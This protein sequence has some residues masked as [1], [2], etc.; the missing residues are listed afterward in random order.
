MT[1][2]NFISFNKIIIVATIGT[3]VEWAEFSCYGYLAP[4][5]AQL[6]FALEQ[7]NAMLLSFAIFSA[8]YL[9][10]P[11]GAIIFGYIGDNYGR[12]LAL[13]ISLMT[14]GV[15]TFAIAIL[16]TYKDLGVMAPL[17]LLFLRLIQGLALSGEFTGAAIF[18]AEHYSGHKRTVVISWISSASAAGMLIGVTL[19][20]LVSIESMPGWSWRLPFAMGSIGCVLG[21]LLRRNTKESPQFQFNRLGVDDGLKSNI[22]ILD[23]SFIQCFLIAAFVSVYIYICNV[24]WL[25]YMVE[26][27]YFSNEMAHLL[28]VLG[29]VGVV[30]LTPVAAGLADLYSPRA[31][32]SIGLASAIVVVPAIFMLSQT[33]QYICG[34]LAALLYALTN[35]LVTGPMF[36]YLTGLFPV[37]TRYSRLGVSWSAAV[38]VVGGTAP[39][40]AQSLFMKTANVMFVVAYVVMLSLLA[41]FALNVRNSINKNSINKT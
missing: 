32:M 40:M 26:Q 9:A 12:K 39:T 7:K 25:S 21:W 17:L 3:V 10:R 36:E 6:F 11:V 29:V 15:A 28:A 35:V 2:N 38:A 5:L 24:W 4:R 19:A 16:P 14:M 22:T 34:I 13:T 1:K 27:Q 41:F 23:F 20:A 30:L 18:I 8:S 31:V 37:R 33:G